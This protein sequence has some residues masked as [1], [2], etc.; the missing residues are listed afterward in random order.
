MTRV[1]PWPGN[2]DWRFGWSRSYS[3]L[4]EKMGIDLP[5]YNGDEA[6][7]LPIPGTYVVGPG[8]HRRTGLCGR[9]LYHPA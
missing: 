5:K 1:T 3:G 9:R 2:S 7:E 6:W 4:F 8:W